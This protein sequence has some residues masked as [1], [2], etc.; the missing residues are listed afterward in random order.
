[1]GISFFRCFL[2]FLVSQCQ[3][4]S[5]LLS[6]AGGSESRIRGEG[7]KHDFASSLL[8]FL[9]KREIEGRDDEP[10]VEAAESAASIVGRPKRLRRSLEQWAMGAARN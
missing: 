7:K 4:N 10:R 8:K 5:R 1:M 3:I 6:P 9:M 2:F